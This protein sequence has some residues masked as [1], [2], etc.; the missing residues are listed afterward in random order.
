[1]KRDRMVCD[2]AF[3]AKSE[4][5]SN[6]TRNLNDQVDRL[7]VTRLSRRDHFSNHL[8]GGRLQKPIRGYAQ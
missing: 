5:Y 2:I 1:M 3:D 4:E 8:F 7:A 6:E